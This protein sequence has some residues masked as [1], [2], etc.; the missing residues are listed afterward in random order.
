M[1]TESFRKTKN[2]YRLKRKKGEAMSKAFYTKEQA[3]QQLKEC[4]EANN[5]NVT[6]LLYEKEKRRPSATWIRKHFGSWRQA[7]KEAGVYNKKIHN[8]NEQTIINQLRACAED[9]NGKINKTL[10]KKSKR[11]PSYDF[12]C[13]YFGSWSK[14]VSK[15]GIVQRSTV[16]HYKQEDMIQ[17]LQTCYHQYGHI[18]KRL[19]E[20]FAKE[21][22]KPSESAISNKFGSWNEALQAAELPLNAVRK[23]TYKKEEMITVLRTCYEEHDKTIT[24][25]IYEKWRKT[26]HP[27]SQTI[28]NYFGSWLEALELAGITYTREVYTEEEM[29]MKLKENIAKLNGNCSP[30]Q[31]MKHYL[32]P[33]LNQYILR[34]GS[35]ENALKRIGCSS[36]KL[37]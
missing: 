5:Q 2:R 22:K 29:V 12:I 13:A 35:W 25:E 9:H 10:Y 33:S 14:A 7:M 21:H 31:Y 4:Y 36:K 24:L 34:F 32:T 27:A 1:M 3:I 18:S 6:I 37:S 11:K 30:R 17:S 26:E 20:T 15:T 16:I 28:V 19:Y 8:Y 23:K